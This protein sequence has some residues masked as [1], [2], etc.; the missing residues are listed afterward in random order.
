MIRSPFATRFTVFGS[1]NPDNR[2]SRRANR[3]PFKPSKSELRHA[4]DY[5]ERCG[6][7]AEANGY[8]EAL[9]HG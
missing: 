8:R 6:A 4:I 2:R 1:I 7:T 3:T 9:K 5:A